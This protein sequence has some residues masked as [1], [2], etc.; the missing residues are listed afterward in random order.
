MRGEAEN[1]F[2]GEWSESD[3]E[4]SPF[5]RQLTITKAKK[6]IRRHTKK[7]R[8]RGQKGSSVFLLCSL[9]C[10][11]PFWTSWCSYLVLLQ[12]ICREIKLIALVYLVIAECIQCWIISSQLLDLH[13]RCSWFIT[14]T[15]LCFQVRPL[16]KEIHFLH[17]Q[18]KQLHLSHL[19]AIHLVNLRRMRIFTSNSNSS[20]LKGTKAFRHDPYWLSR[21]GVVMEFVSQ[22][23]PVMDALE[24]KRA[25]ASYERAC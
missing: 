9:Y 12:C 10:F 17:L 5:A 3:A 24:L 14:R 23:P 11:L 7:F 6:L 8:S 22:P 21:S 16:Y 2:H 4:F 1:D 25:E 15:S 18:G 19:K 13:A 20:H